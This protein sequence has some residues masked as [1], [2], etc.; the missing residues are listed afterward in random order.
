MSPS[1]FL[2][3]VL[4]FIFPKSELIFELEHLPMDKLLTRLP[5]PKEIEDERTLA[6]FDY[7]DESV[8][9]MI[10]ALKSARGSPRYSPMCSLMKSLNELCLKSLLNLSSSLYP[11]QTSAVENVVGTKQK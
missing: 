2:D 10:W 1:Q 3:Y 9:E 5:A 4:D 11:S 6:L 8:R 7:S